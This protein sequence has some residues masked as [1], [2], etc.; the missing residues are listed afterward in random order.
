MVGQGASGGAVNATISGPGAALVISNSAAEFIVSQGGGTAGF[1][2]TNLDTFTAYVSRLGVGVPPNYGWNVLR[3]AGNGT[4]QLAR[5]N[6]ITVYFNLPSAATNYTNWAGYNYVA[7][8]EIQ[9]AIEVGNGAD[10]SIGAASTL[11]L[12]ESNAFFIDSIGVGKSKSTSGHALRAFNP[13]FT[14][15][16]PTVFFRGTNGSTKLSVTFFQPSGDVM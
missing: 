16:N 12:G 6:T 5:T 15:S 14:N 1:N 3:Q 9:E 8:H 10:N 11:Y 13:A 7:G 2:M 4:L